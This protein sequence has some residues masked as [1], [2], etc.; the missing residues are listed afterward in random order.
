MFFIKKKP[1]PIKE[2]TMSYFSE[3]YRNKL[4]QEHKLVVTTINRLTERYKQYAVNNTGD[5]ISV[6]LTKLRGE[7]AEIEAKIDVLDEFLNG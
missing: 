7:K 6:A 2:R 5:A 3:E 1:N 4:I